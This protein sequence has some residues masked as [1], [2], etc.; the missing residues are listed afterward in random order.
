MTEQGWWWWWWVVD[1]KM[2]WVDLSER[3]P[4]FPLILNDKKAIGGRAL[5]AEEI[6]NGHILGMVTGP[7]KKE[8][9]VGNLAD[10]V[11]IPL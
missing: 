10:D 8:R 9:G 6:T 4:T 1:Q 2:L 11:G 3:I 7:D 5:P